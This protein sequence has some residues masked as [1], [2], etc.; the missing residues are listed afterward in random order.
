M[1]C[2]PINNTAPAT[3]SSPPPLSPS[4]PFSSSSSPYTPTTPPSV[5]KNTAPASTPTSPRTPTQPRMQARPVPQQLKFLKEI[6]LFNTL[7]HEV[8]EEGTSKLVFYASSFL[9]SIFDFCS[10]VSLSLWDLCDCF[11]SWTE[12]AP[13]PEP[14][15]VFG[16]LRGKCTEADCACPVFVLPTG[17]CGLF[18]GTTSSNERESRLVEYQS[19]R[20]RMI[21]FCFLFLPPDSKDVQCMT[22]THFPFKHENLGK[23]DGTYWWCFLMWVSQQWCL[24]SLS[25]PLWLTFG[26]SVFVFRQTRNR[27]E[28]KVPRLCFGC[29]CCNT[30]NK[31]ILILIFCLSFSIFCPFFFFLFLFAADTCLPLCHGVAK[32]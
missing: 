27:E 20:I 29:S 15:V 12:K 8:E 30:A 26:G 9:A 7:V 1:Y 14:A 17:M 28:G 31:S 23:A 19:W 5:H 13:M 4:S 21:V 18:K 3:P 10:L 22:C 11:F 6:H 24:L 16:V 2:Q 32:K 25:C